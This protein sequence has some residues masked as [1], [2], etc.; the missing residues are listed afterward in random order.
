MIETRY[1]FSL[2]NLFIV[3]IRKHK[4]KY[5]TTTDIVFIEKIFIER[6]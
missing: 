2:V 4:H 3:I 6:S 5:D 1:V